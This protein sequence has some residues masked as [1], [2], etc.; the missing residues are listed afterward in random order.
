MMG[1]KNLD[2]GVFVLA[3][4]VVLYFLCCLSKVAR[5]W[6]K[7]VA[8]GV[9]Y[10]LVG[11]LVIPVSL[12]N[13]GEMANSSYFSFWCKALCTKYIFQFKMDVKNRHY[14]ERTEPTVILS[15]HQSALDQIGVM[16]AWP[17]GRC[18][19]LAKRS[20]MYA[21]TFGIASLL[22]GVVFVDRFNPAKAKEFTKKVTDIIKKKQTK[23]WI[24]PEGTRSSG[25]GRDMLPFKKG[26]FF[27]A[28]EAQVPIT[29]VVFSNYK[30]TYNPKQYRFDPCNV[31][32]TVLPPVPTEGK[33]TDDIPSLME[34]IREMM[35]DVYRKT[36]KT[37]EEDHTQ[38]NFTENHIQHSAAS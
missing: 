38:H 9:W 17:S 22:C 6:L 35:L 4:A 34:E 8:V 2:M 32:I 28:V 27:I 15:N 36:S 29:P 13:P 20:L 3:A 21:G 7:I 26:A 24:Y 12:L 37:C 31:I 19:M 10:I 1:W 23:V 14:L 5:F 33:T 25:T 11:I 18:T 30:D 16:E